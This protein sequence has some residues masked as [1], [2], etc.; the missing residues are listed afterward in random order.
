MNKAIST[1]I[2]DEIHHVFA[3]QKEQ[4]WILKTSSAAER[5]E[6]LKRLRVALEKYDAE[7]RAALLSDLR[8]S[9]EMAELEIGSCYVD[10]DDAV[11]NLEKWMEPIEITPSEPYADGKAKITYEARGIVLLFGPWNFPF[12]LVIQPLVSIIAAGN[13]A[14]VKPNEMAAETSRISAKIIREVFDE[15]EVAVFEGG[16]DLANRLLE[17]PVNHIF[18][19]GSPAVGKVIMTAAAKHLA[20]IT[21]ELGGKNPVV[22][23]RSANLQDAAGKIATFR[24][25]N[26]G[27]ICLSPENVWVPEEMKDEFLAM[28][29]ATWQ[30]AFYSDGQLNTEAI[31]KI[32]DERNIERV[33]SYIED[34]RNKGATIVCG[35]NTEPESRAI[36]PTLLTD[37]PQ[38]AVILGEETFGP[39]LA[40]FTY[41][42]VGEAIDAIREQPKPLALYVFAQDEAFVE[43]ILQSTSSGGVTVNNCVLHA[44]ETRLPF[45]GVNNSG[46]GRYHSVHG[47]KELSHER[48]VLFTP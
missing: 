5:I 16:V 2:A 29:Q 28:V 38:D 24:V 42:E 37:I 31:G 11:E 44:A 25:L 26:S 30:A 33:N 40:V 45:G 46:M 47:F 8:K 39:V 35:G 32:I 1:P 3:L 34:A 20:T 6:R 43:K 12:S 18:F 17:L 36:H 4:Q 19:T 7:I 41:K 27:Q 14:L 10:I 22:I 9:G 21:L 48:A 23:D 15:K 13:C